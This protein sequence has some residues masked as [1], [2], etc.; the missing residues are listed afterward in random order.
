MTAPSP[1][2][3]T[4]AMSAAQSALSRLEASGDVDTDEAAAL[5]ILRDEAPEIDEVLR[6]LLR[7]MDEAGYNAETATT[8]AAHLKARAARFERQHEEYRRTVFAIMDALGVRKSKSG[9]F[10]VSISDGRPGIVITD[11]AALPDAFIRTTRAPDKTAIKDAIARGEHV[12]G[13]A[14][15]NNPP[16]L[17]V[18]TK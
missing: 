10:T 12:P 5:A 4:A 18:R 7:A 15:Q 8:R 6:R 2:A 9:E 13:V 1:Y 16:V 17:T 3:I 11:E 14:M